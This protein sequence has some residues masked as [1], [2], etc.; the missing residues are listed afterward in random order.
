[1]SGGTILINHHEQLGSGCTNI[2]VYFYNCTFVRNP[3]KT[4]AA[5][6]ITKHGVLF[7]KLHSVPQVSVTFEMCSI[8]RNFLISEYSEQVNL[9]LSSTGIVLY[10]SKLFDG[11]V[12]NSISDHSTIV[13]VQTSYTVVTM[14]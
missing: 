9:A 14:S 1:M 12:A 4:G 6:R 11:E 2:D 8:A 13:S 7:Y 10:I 3:A 5:V